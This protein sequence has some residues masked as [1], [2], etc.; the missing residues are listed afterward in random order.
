MTG[1]LSPSLPAVVRQ[2]LGWKVLCTWSELHMQL[3]LSA[4]EVRL[5]GSLPVKQLGTG[6]LWRG[7]KQLLIL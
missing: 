1:D 3:L 2:L 7:E 5:T 4:A 6:A